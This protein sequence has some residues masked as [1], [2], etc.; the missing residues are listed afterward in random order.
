MNPWNR[1]RDM[2][3]R[4]ISGGSALP[5]SGEAI[6]LTETAYR[7]RRQ[8]GA[9]APEIR[10][11]HFGL[12]S[13]RKR[14]LAADAPAHPRGGLLARLRSRGRAEKDA[15]CYSRTKIVG[16]P[17]PPSPQPPASAPAHEPAQAISQTPAPAATLAAAA[18]SAPSMEKPLASPMPGEAALQ[19]QPPARIAQLGPKDTEMLRNLFGEPQQSS[20]LPTPLPSPLA[21]PLPRRAA[22][23]AVKPAPRKPATP[24]PSRSPI[25]KK[26]KKMDRGD[27]TVAALGLT[28]A[29]ICAIF[30]WYIF[31]NQEKFG[32]REFVFSGAGASSRP[33]GLA[34]VPQPVGKPFA[35]TEVPKLALDFFPTATLPAEGD[36]PRAIPA[37]EQPFP[38]DKLNFRLVHV[39]NG[40]AMIEDGDGLWVVQRG[41]Q[42]PDASRVVSIEQRKGRWV[43]LTSRDGIVELGAN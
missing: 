37:S 27:L 32:V 15:Q 12:G 6:Y 10:E 29:A 17:H 36:A 21:S 24:A 33:S 35:S 40:R 16:T 4:L 25:V 5:A 39:A 1:L 23:A 7:N 8:A 11:R 14:A 22:A 19:K 31:F 20:P 28:L 18:N 42:L 2:A 9:S 26:R 3:G 34:Y 43:L 13:G 30:P 38:A 41:S